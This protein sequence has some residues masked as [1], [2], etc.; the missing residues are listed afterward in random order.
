MAG[1][2]RGSPSASGEGAKRA[3]GAVVHKRGD[4]VL[5]TEDV[6]VQQC[7]C[8]GT[9][10]GGL[11]ADIAQRMGVDFYKERMPILPGRNLATRQTW[12]DPGTM[13]VQQAHSGVWVVGLM[14][15]VF[16]GRP[17]VWSS[18]IPGIKD[19]TSDRLV[20]FARGLRL[21]HTWMRDHDAC[22]VAFPSR[23]GCG[24]AGGEWSTYYEMLRMF[25]ENHPEYTVVIYTLAT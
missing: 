15:Q 4:L 24:L 22:R 6:I 19:E 8:V 17:G 2:K 3:R 14:G 13:A 5:A 20:Y 9:R 12:A 21:L 16:Y 25:A 18:R 23:I 10:P 11:A 1:Q 7:N